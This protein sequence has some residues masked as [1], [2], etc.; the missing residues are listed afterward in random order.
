M[1]EWDFVDKILYINLEESVDRRINIEN[2]LLKVI[3][4]DK[5]MRFNAIKHEYGHIGCTMSHIQCLEI[6]IKNNWN[7]VLILEDDAVFEDYSKGL[8]LLKNL[9]VNNFDV[10]SLGS[11]YVKF[12]ENT[13]RL[14]EGQ[15]TTAYL[16]N[17]HYFLTLI[18]NF[19]EGLELLEN[20]KIWKKYCVDQYWKLLQKKDN[21]YI[22]FPPLIIQAPGY[23]FIRKKYVDT[24]NLFKKI[25]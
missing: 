25:I 4:S 22:V 3:P 7:N 8:N 16:V 1:N 24:T 5:I 12:D 20:T 10:I 6:A 14:T 9:I 21:W 11:M 13:Y 23:S 2:E 18:N 15:T 19:K 17:N